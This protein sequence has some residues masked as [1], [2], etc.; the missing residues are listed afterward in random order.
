MSSLPEVPGFLK[1]IKP[2]IKISSDHE[3][4]DPVVAYWCVLYA[5]QTGLKMDAKPKDSFTFLT[6]LMD[7][8]ETAK[9]QQAGNEAVS[10]E[11]VAQAHMENYAL[12]LFL[13]ADS[14]DRA[15]NFSKNLIK[16]FYTAGLLF[17][18][19]TVFGEVS[20]EAKEECSTMRNQYDV[21]SCD[22]RLLTIASTPSGKPPTSTTVSTRAS[23]LSL[24]LL[25]ERKTQIWSY[26]LMFIKASVITFVV[27]QISKLARSLY[28]D[29]LVNKRYWMVEWCAEFGTQPPTTMHQPEERFDQ[30]STS[31]STPPYYNPTPPAPNPALTPQAPPPSYYTDDLAPQTPADSKCLALNG[32]ELTP[33]DL[34]L[35]QKLCKWAGSALTYDDIPTAVD[36]LQKVLALLTTGQKP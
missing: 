22:G 4:R 2:Y 17:D 14:E 33:A 30:P 21:S 28:N 25:V 32:A 18:V 3:K 35:G 15:G 1:S 10:S 19:L 5:L 34:Q 29:R 11:V 8:L 31:I 6:R 27:Y 13:W 12:K 36:N 16:T 20:E 24:V 23:L 26:Y 7:W 9:R